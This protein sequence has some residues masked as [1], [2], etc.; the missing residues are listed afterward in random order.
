MAGRL[1]T[2]CGRWGL[3]EMKNIFAE[4]KKHLFI[5]WMFLK[6][7]L[8]AQME[9]RV[10]FFTGIAMECGYLVV[11][12]L[13]VIVIYRSG[14]MINGLSP[15]A[16]LLFVGTFV[17]ITG[18]YAGLFMM[19]FFQLREQIRSGSLDLLIT[20]PVSLQFILTLR[21][22]DMGIMVIDVTA[23]AIMVAI[24]WN[25]LHLPFD[26]INALG[27]IGF[28][29][30]GAVVG[31]AIFLLPQ[32]LSFWL[33]NTSAIAEMVDSF[34]DFNNVP[35]TIYNNY[36]QR[37]GVFLLPIFVVTNFPALFVLGRMNLI[38]IIWGIIAPFIFMGITR[39]FW[40]LAIRNYTSASS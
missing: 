32:I 14:K 4:L 28:L 36:I 22:S 3:T 1:Q 31:Y 11:K 16:I 34:W 29:L 2:I 19:N 30:S 33:I 35:M 12:I 8:A 13:Y 18:F 26:L 37:F 6:N 27:F 23:G 7:C 5:Y 39:A 40:Q 24:G 21:R 17:I 38:Y 15:D 25:R 9:Y 20:K 10:N